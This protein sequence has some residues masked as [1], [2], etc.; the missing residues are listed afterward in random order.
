MP[1]NALIKHVVMIIKENHTFDNY[2]GTFPGA[3]GDAT[4][5]RAADP[6]PRD[7]PHNHGAWLKRAAGAVQEQYIEADIP[8]YFAY[9]RQFTLCDNFFTEVA[10][11]SIPNHLMLIAAASP[12]MDNPHK[13]DPPALQP[14]FNLK[15]LP[16]RLEEA[17]LDWRVYGGDFIFKNITGLL[18]RGKNHGSDQFVVD[19]AKGDLPAVTWLYSEALSEHPPFAGQK[20][21]VVGPGMQWTV[22][23]VNAVVQGGLW[24]NTVVFITWDDWGGWFD[25][26]EPK[27]VEQ[28]PAN[29][30]P[31]SYQN[32]QFSY[33]PRV[34]CL[35]LSPFAKG[36][37][38]SKVFH[39]HVSLVKFCETTFG[40]PA[41]NARD[42][43]SDDMSDCFDFTQHAA[44]PPA[45][46]PPPGQGP[47]PGPGPKPAQPPKPRP[48]P[49]PKPKPKPRPKAKPKA[50]PK[51]PKKR[52]K[53][54]RRKK[55]YASKR[56]SKR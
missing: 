2:F 31:A 12:L 41:L 7:P 17:G 16:T 54:L 9:A 43:K 8:A 15:S 52:T 29:G 19:A 34:G 42:A 37:H 40:V 35:V 3:N 26:V 38:I 45:G 51:P 49:H 55:R 33:G 14:P 27:N 47:K 25:H 53:P 11:Q 22:E 20:G 39:S 32:T 6:P 1:A 50:K 48:K 46:V 24:P 18:G 28:W 4:L 10:S 56:G 36:G 30:F 13:G 5:A 21:P 23:Q 44:P